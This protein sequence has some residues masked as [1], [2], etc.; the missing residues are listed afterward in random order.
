MYTKMRKSEGEMYMAN[1]KIKELGLGPADHKLPQ[2]LN[3]YV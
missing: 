1:K 2:G 3:W